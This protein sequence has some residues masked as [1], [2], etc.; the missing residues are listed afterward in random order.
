MLVYDPAFRISAQHAIQHPYCTGRSN[1]DIIPNSSSGS[2][3]N[4]ISTYS[5]HPDTSMALD[6]NQSGIYSSELHLSSINSNQGAF[7]TDHS[8]HLVT[9]S[10]NFSG[11]NSSKPYDQHSNFHGNSNISHIG[12]K[13]RGRGT[14]GSAQ[15]IR[16]IIIT[17]S[18]IDLH[19][20]YLL[21]G[22]VQHRCPYLRLGLKII[23]WL[24]SFLMVRQQIAL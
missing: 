5:A 21:L 22:L 20:L 11:N 2:D 13:R 16:Y 3:S 17:F 24:L 10:D 7:Y 4:R 18:F 14:T 1:L 15:R 9:S 23:Q 19:S 12:E 8:A 6:Y